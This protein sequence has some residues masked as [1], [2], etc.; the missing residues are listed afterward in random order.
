MGVK[1]DKIDAFIAIAD[2]TRRKILSLLAAG[3]M[4]ITAVSG[5]F[6]ISRPA[7]SKHLSVLQEAGLISVVEQGRERYCQLEQDGFEE[8]SDWLAFYEQFWQQKL[9]ELEK[10]VRQRAAAKKR[11]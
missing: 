10:V 8:I 6:E 4:T 1:Y 5:H 2:P 9:V 11:A 7:V 3:S